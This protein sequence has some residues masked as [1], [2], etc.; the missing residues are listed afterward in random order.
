MPSGKEMD[1]YIIWDKTLRRKSV[2]PVE[3]LSS[4]LLVDPCGNSLVCSRSHIW[5]V[6]KQ[7]RTY[8]IY[9]LGHARGMQ[10]FSG[11]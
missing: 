8:L 7:G 5:L 2:L 3:S 1:A 6:A 9:V 10:K 4:C 11:Y